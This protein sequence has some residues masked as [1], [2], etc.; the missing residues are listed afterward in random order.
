[1]L[2][3]DSFRARG[4]SSLCND[5]ERNLT[6]ADRAQ[7]ALGARDWLAQQ[8]FIAAGRIGL[9]GWSNGGST[10]LEV[11]G[12]TAAMGA[13]GFRAVVAF[14]P[15]CRAILKRGWTARVPTTILHG[16]ADDWTP[17]AP[18]QQL[19]SRGGAQFVGYPEAY[20]GFDHPNLSRRERKAA[21]SERAD[22]LVTLGTQAEARAQAIAATMAVL[23]GM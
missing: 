22:G 4:V 5:R 7:D 20:H 11:A 14:Y 8:R 2:L 12:N 17:A 19:A 18:C 1:V 23:Q 3:P 21:Y 15:G 10:A 13:D 9:I 6:P 16:L